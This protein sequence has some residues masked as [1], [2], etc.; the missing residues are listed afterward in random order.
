MPF[1][2]LRKLI[3]TKKSAKPAKKRTLPVKKKVVIK[4]SPPAIKTRILTAEGWKR[5]FGPLAL[6]A[7]KKG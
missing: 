6:K 7:K 2:T 5:R 3:G 4:K 1:V